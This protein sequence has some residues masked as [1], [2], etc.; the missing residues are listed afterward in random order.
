LPDRTWRARR[1]LRVLT[2]LR[3]PVVQAPELMVLQA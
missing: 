2:E 3:Q 1:V